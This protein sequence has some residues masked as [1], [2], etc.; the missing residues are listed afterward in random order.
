MNCPRRPE[1]MLRHALTKKFPELLGVDMGEINTEEIAPD[2]RNLIEPEL[3]YDQAAKADLVIKNAMLTSGETVDIA[4]AE[5]IITR[6]GAAEEVAEVTDSDTKILDA[7]GQSVA[8]GFIDSHLHLA[9]AMQRLGSMDAE[10]I[11][12][13][14]DFNAKV[15]KFAEE[16]KDR[17]VLYVF[18]LHY[19]DDPIIPAET[20]RFE[21]DKL[22]DDKPLVV[23]AH[24]LHTAWGNT[25][26]LDEAGVLHKMPPYP[27]LIEEL[28]LEGKIVTDN[29]GM[30]TGEFREPEGL[31]FPGRSAASQIPPFRGATA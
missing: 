17:P 26:A 28:D 5:N 10:P 18:G 14:E 1:T 20:C 30:P 25:K 2:T 15:K 27:H 21:L 13:K 8:P 29:D 11:T 6:V 19:F 12:A 7:G 4:V 23:Y 24:D 16:N 9:V 31:L 3:E 22:V